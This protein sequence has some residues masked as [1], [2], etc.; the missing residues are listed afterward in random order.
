MIKFTNGEIC[1]FLSNDKNLHDDDNQSLNIFSLTVNVKCNYAVDSFEI[2]KKTYDRNSCNAF[3]EIESIAGCTLTKTYLISSVFFPGDWMVIPFFLVFGLIMI[4]SG[5]NRIRIS[6]SLLIYFAMNCY[7]FYIFLLID[8]I[9]RTFI[10]K[11]TFWQIGLILS[12]SL[13]CFL[14]IFLS[15]KNP[16]FPVIYFSKGFLFGYY[17]YSLLY[18]LIFYQMYLANYTLVFMYLNGICGFFFGCVFLFLFQNFDEYE[19][20]STKI[21]F[22]NKYLKIIFFSFIGSYFLMRGVS[23]IF[24]MYLDYSMLIFLFE[25][26]EESLA[27][28]FSDTFMFRYTVLWI[29]LFINGIIFQVKISIEKDKYKEDKKA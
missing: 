24:G 5:Y 18:N 3:V 25:K 26:N 11:V 1:K 4:I 29:V 17:M 27:H 2:I 19:K 28:E 21:A 12:K 22:L 13:L 7:C 10:S 15:Y 16:S 14:S 9:F 6:N 8:S 20:T 23:M